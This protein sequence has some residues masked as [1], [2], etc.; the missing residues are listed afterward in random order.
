MS[1]FKALLINFCFFFSIATYA[2]EVPIEFFP[3]DNYSQEI[4][5]YLPKNDPNYKTPLMDHDLQQKKYQEFLKHY[6]STETLSPWSEKMVKAVIPMVKDLQI[7]RIDN[8]NQDNTTSFKH[9][10]ENFQSHDNKWIEEIEQ[11]MDLGN[12]SLTFAK[13]KRAIITNNTLLRALPTNEPDFFHFTLPGQGFPF[14]NLQESKAHP[15]TPVYV[16]HLSKDGAWALVLTPDCFFNWVNTKDVGFVS[17]NFIKTWQD[18]AQKNLVAITKHNVSILNSNNQFQFK[19]MVGAVFP[20]LNSQDEKLEILIPVRDKNANARLISGFITKGSAQ[21]M[22]LVLNKENFAKILEELKN[23]P[24]GW[25]GAYFFN[26][27]SLE[28]KSLFTPF[29]IWLPRNSAQQA[30]LNKS[31]DLSNKSLED[32]LK[33]LTKIGKPFLTLVYL[34]GHIMLYVGTQTTNKGDIIISYQ[35]VWGLSPKNKD[36]R[37]IIGKSVFLPLIKNYSEIPEIA[38]QASQK[39]FKLV[40]LDSLYEEYGELKA[41]TQPKQ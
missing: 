12:F 2:I 28:M 8:F 17:D 15:G 39:T 20:L 18:K 31:I 23:K 37:Y 29:G 40:F 26:D 32:R 1:L 38:S 30:L 41:F 36:K 3:I 34:K 33:I 10:G 19:S 5:T 7:M 14:D 16:L 9:Y 22:P 21:N 13:A 25:G 11:N 24:Y 4:E 6:Y 35:N 27:C